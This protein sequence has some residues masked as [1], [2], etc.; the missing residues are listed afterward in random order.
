MFVTAKNSDRAGLVNESSVVNGGD[1]PS[2]KN[3]VL[4]ADP[5]CSSCNAFFFFVPVYMNCNLFIFAEKLTLVC[6]VHSQL[7]VAARLAG[8][9]IDAVEIASTDTPMSHDKFIDIPGDVS[10]QSAGDLTGIFA[11]EDLHFYDRLLQLSVGSIVFTDM[12]VF[13]VCVAVSR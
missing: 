12:G 2:C 1:E 3:P 11:V 5:I 13:Q 10:T 8:A 6:P 9:A 7:A 4:S